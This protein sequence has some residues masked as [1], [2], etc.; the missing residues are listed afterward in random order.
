MATFLTGKDLNDAI[1]DVIWNA[2][3]SLVIVSPFI[4]LDDYFK[5]LF[6]HHKHNHKLQITIVFGKNESEPRKSLRSQDFDFFKQFKNISIIYCANLHAKY[7]AN[8]THGILTSINLYD[9]SFKNNIE[10]GVLYSTGLLNSLTN[11]ADKA[12]WSYSF[13]IADIHPAIFIKRPVYDKSLFG[14]LLGQKNY[15]DSDVLHDQTEVLL[16][17]WSRWEK[18]TKKFLPEFEEELL[19]NNKDAKRPDRT[20]PTPVK[21]TSPKKDYSNNY[22]NNV[23]SNRQPANQTGYCIRTGVEIPFNPSKPMCADAY[24]KWS[25]FGNPD[26][27]ENYC[28][29]TGKLS[30]GKTSMREPIL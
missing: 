7:Y 17:N 19:S 26:Y 2:N 6:E 21:E 27:Q 15:V 23:S 18:E 4:K 24:K 9:S 14:G 16:K 29:K 22:N 1:Y 28:H 5:Q 25:Q 3:E 11:G 20:D 10:Y 8:D 30:F 13:E 12:A